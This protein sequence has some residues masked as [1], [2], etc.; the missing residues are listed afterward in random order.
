[1]NPLS[2][3]NKGRGRIS[4]FV[5]W[6]AGSALIVSGLWQWHEAKS[7]LGPAGI[8]KVM[9]RELNNCL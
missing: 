2:K 9:F 8:F 1:M 5:F 6:G 7:C 3:S 4:N